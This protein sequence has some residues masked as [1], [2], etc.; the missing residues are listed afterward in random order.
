MLGNTPWPVKQLLLLLVLL[1]SFLLLGAKRSSSDSSYYGISVGD[2]IDE[3][4]KISSISVSQEDDVI[5]QFHES[6]RKIIRLYSRALSKSLWCK[7]KLLLRFLLISRGLG[8]SQ[9]TELIKE[10]AVASLNTMK[11]RVEHAH[12]LLKT[13]I[14]ERW[15]YGRKD[16]SRRNRFA[17]GKHANHREELK[18]EGARATRFRQLRSRGDIIGGD[19][20]KGDIRDFRSR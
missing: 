10:W 11:D 14:A 17:S 1:A 9:Q 5:D 6:V 13:T 18:E 15:R 12:K 16:G 4:D 8:E 2:M 7:R 19:I 3:F 20:I